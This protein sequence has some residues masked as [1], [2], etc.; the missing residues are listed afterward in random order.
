MMCTTIGVGRL[1]RLLL[2]SFISLAHRQI[3]TADAAVV[4]A[5]ASNFSCCRRTTLYSTGLEQAN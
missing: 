5:D 4:S 2:Q 1:E 3:V